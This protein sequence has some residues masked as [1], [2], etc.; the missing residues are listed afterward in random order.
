[1]SEQN[2]LNIWRS[3]RATFFLFLIVVPILIVAN[4]SSGEIEGST[5]DDLLIPAAGL[6]L[7]AGFLA[8]AGRRTINHLAGAPLCRWRWDR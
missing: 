3:L 1:M 5:G 4:V 2:A 6:I 8:E 7:F